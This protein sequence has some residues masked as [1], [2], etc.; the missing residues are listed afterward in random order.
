MGRFRYVDR[1][2]LPP[3]RLS[4]LDQKVAFWRNKWMQMNT[5][6]CIN[7]DFVWIQEILLRLASRSNS[8]LVWA[9]IDWGRCSATW[10]RSVWS[11][12][13]VGSEAVELRR[14]QCGNSVIKEFVMN[15]KQDDF[16]EILERVNSKIVNSN[17][18]Q[19][20]IQTEEYVNIFGIKVIQHIMIK[21]SK[22]STHQSHF[23]LFG[24]VW[25]RSN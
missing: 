11:A 25:N 14:K 10:H 16:R 21:H 2:Y 13:G 1:S 8:L 22:Y 15:S 17:V 23:D 7:C 3:S 12:S 5:R 24:A 9:A 6:R 4:D 18:Y 19:S 20:K